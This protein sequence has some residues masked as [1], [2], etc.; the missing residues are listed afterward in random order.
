MVYRSCPEVIVSDKSPSYMMYWIIGVMLVLLFVFVF[1]LVG[2]NEG[3]GRS[4][5]GV[6]I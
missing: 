2:V 5:L 3:I 4:A 1:V 6:I